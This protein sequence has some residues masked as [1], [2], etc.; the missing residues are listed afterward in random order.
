MPYAWW[1]WMSP[2]LPAKKEL[3]CL[4][5]RIPNMSARAPL[6]KKAT[7]GKGDQKFCF[8]KPDAQRPKLDH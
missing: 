5:L 6:E 8:Q 7:A 4:Q 3:S 2:C 1:L